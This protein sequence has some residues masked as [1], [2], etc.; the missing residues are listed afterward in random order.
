MST[1]RLN[2]E[3]LIRAGN[4][5]P[6]LWSNIRDILDIF[7]NVNIVK[8]CLGVGNCNRIQMQL[9]PFHRIG[10]SGIS[11]LAVQGEQRALF[12]TIVNLEQ[13]TVISIRHSGRIGKKFTSQILLCIDIYRTLRFGIHGKMSIG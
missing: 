2:H 1:F 5:L 10:A 6:L 9:A 12:G 8:S 11:I 4:H 3:I 13:L 7:I